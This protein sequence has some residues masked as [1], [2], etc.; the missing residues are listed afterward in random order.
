MTIPG[1]F[2]SSEQKYRFQ[3]AFDKI[4]LKCKKIQ[5]VVH[6]ISLNMCEQICSLLSFIMERQNM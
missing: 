3:I 2:H 6:D 4:R 5:N 1:K